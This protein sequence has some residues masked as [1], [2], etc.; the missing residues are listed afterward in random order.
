[1][2]AYAIVS[3][4]KIEHKNEYFEIRFT[5]AAQPHRRSIFFTTNEENLEVV[6]RQVLADQGI[7][8]EHWLVVPHAKH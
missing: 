8:A 3:E 5:G 1:M 2:A 4:D 7:V 6:A